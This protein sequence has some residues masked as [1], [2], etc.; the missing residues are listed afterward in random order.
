MPKEKVIKYITDL[1]TSKG[2]EFLLLTRNSVESTSGQEIFTKGY[3]TENISNKLPPH[4]FDLIDIA[5]I[6]YIS[7]GLRVERNNEFLTTILLKVDNQN[8][9][10]NYIFDSLKY[11]RQIPCKMLAKLWIKFIEPKKKIQYP[12]IGG[13]DTKPN[14]W[15][16]NI[17]HR[18]PDHLQKPERLELMYHILVHVLPDIYSLEFIIELEELSVTESVIKNDPKKKNIIKTLF[19][20]TVHLKIM[21]KR[22]IPV[23]DLSQ[24]KQRKKNNSQVNAS[25][26]GMFPMIVP[27][28][29]ANEACYLGETTIINTTAVDQ[30]F[31]I[32]AD[33][34]PR[35]LFDFLI[36][37]P[38]DFPDFHDDALLDSSSSSFSATDHQ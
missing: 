24:N 4:L 28:S 5:N 19:N 11:L 6:E 32:M 7:Q 34:D 36:G 20:I 23:M 38:S 26:Q 1:L 15:P 10:K 31:N 3:I 9:I 27:S 2:Y 12:Y 18:E 8:E 30:D 35:L 17:Q 16:T 14:W 25:E 13:D 22:A 29:N 33:T 37:S 21:E